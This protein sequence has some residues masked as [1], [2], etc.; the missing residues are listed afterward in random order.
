[1]CFVVDIIESL[2]LSR[3]SLISVTLRLQE[4]KYK[5]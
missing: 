2:T 4:A 3:A 1:M 5:F